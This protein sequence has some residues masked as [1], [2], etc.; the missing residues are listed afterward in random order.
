MECH[1]DRLPERYTSTG[2]KDTMSAMVQPAMELHECDVAQPTA[3][4]QLMV[5]ASRRTLVT[6]TVTL[7][8]SSRD[9]LWRAMLS[10]L[11]G[12]VEKA[13]SMVKS[14][15]LIPKNEVGQ[16]CERVRLP[17]LPREAGLT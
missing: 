13:G 17:R 9:K 10:C 16:A 8:T 15:R 7:T 14:M 1:G 6:R 2:A 11:S 12:P 3:A 5:C 4:C